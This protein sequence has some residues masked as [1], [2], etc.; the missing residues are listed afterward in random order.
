MAED[1]KS[2]H[3]CAVPETSRPEFPADL[4]APRT[5][6]I[7]L[8]ANKWINGTRL[9]YH[10]KTVRQFGWPAGQKQAVRD[11]FDAWK[12]L[13]IGLDFA[14]V[15]AEKDAILVIGLVQGDGSWSY[16][17]TDVIKNRRNGLNMNFG[18]DLTTR[19]GRATAL[20]EIGHALGMP[21]EHQNPQ[22]GIVWDEPKV[23]AHFSG[24]PNNWPDDVIR[25]NILRH[26]PA[27]DVA[28]SQWDPAS[29]M[30]YPFEPGLIQA[31]PPYNANGIPENIGLSA[32]DSA[33]M[34]RF[35]PPLAQ[36]AELTLEEMVPL[37]TTGTE[38]VDFTFTP[39]ETRH[40]RL[41]TVGEADT[42]IAV[43]EMGR[44]GA[45]RM[46]GVA[47]DSAKE[48]N[49][50]L[51]GELEAGKSYRISARTHYAPRPEGARLVLL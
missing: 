43:A 29:I 37:P 51:S 24:P 40:Y 34:R 47:D 30:H 13:G 12:A 9:T 49:A 3:Y 10:F 46:L 15:G 41:Q 8:S 33:W 50:I 6:A 39:T 23:I 42:K 20:H 4:G 36:A 19:W 14:E 48:G 31:P 11:A 45:A 35:Y 16:V 28:G 1:L 17:G 27:G 21:H 25:W 7:L 44:G 22:S 38:Q 18:W 32:N 5:D 2:L 26:L